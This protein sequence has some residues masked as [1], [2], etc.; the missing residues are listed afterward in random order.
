[1]A[2]PTPDIAAIRQRAADAAVNAAHTYLSA[3]HRRLVTEDV[4]ALLDALEWIKTSDRLPE[5]PR[6]RDYEHVE[7]LIYYK[8]QV[9]KR[10]WNCEHL[11]WDDEDGDD[12][13]CDPEEPTHWPPLPAAPV[14]S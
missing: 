7:C 14:Q 5:K 4:P 1:M 6:K 13:F 10:P 2:D 9:L 11:C 12:F 3:D 8:N